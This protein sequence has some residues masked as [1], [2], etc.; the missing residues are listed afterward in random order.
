MGGVRC[1]GEVW[2]SLHTILCQKKEVSAHTNMDTQYVHT[3]HSQY[4]HTL[5]GC[6]G[7]TVAYCVP[8]VKK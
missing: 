3:L 7:R 1:A 5:T 2:S 6:G 8:Y 4:I